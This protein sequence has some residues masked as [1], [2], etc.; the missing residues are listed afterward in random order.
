MI[1]KNNFEDLKQS[2]HLDKNSSKRKFKSYFN[3][4]MDLKCCIRIL[5]FRKKKFKLLKSKLLTKQ[6]RSS[7]TKKK[8]LEKL[9]KL[10]NF[11]I[12]R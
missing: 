11:A 6:T 10:K 2:S 4:Y 7:F 3:Q 5:I 1:S 9:T 12:K 8:T